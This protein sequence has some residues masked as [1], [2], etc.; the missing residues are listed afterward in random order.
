[1]PEISMEI[2]K[3]RYNEEK[4]GKAKLRLLAAIHRKSSKTIDEICNVLEK[5]KTTIHRW[6]NTFSCKGINGKNTIKQPGRTP[7]LSIK[8]RKKLLQML[9]RGP[10]H[11][12]KGL[13]TTKQVKELIK[14]KYGA[15]F[16]NQHIWR[17]LIALGFS[18]QRP[19]KRHHKHPSDDEIMRFKKKL[20]EKRDIIPPRGLLWAHKMKQ[21]LGSYQISLADGHEEGV[22]Q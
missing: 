16:V 12:P 2:L 22:A 7:L 13:W 18:L 1:M 19:R 9:E 20:G 11:N 10:P 4:D 5:P 8:Q 15:V 3:R 14:H 6:L 21:H 17:M